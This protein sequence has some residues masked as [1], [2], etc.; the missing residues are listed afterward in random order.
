MNRKTLVVLLAFAGAGLLAFA[1]LKRDGSLETTAVVFGLFV[2]L[3]FVELFGLAFRSTRLVAIVILSVS[4][5]AAADLTY[6]YSTRSREA[7]QNYEDLLPTLRSAQEH[8]DLR[9]LTPEEKAAANQAQ[10]LRS[11][12]SVSLRD[13]QLGSFGALA[14]TVCAFVWLI[15][16]FIIPPG[17]NAYPMLRW[18]TTGSILGSLACGIILMLINATKSRYESEVGWFIGAVGGAVG[19]AL[20]GAVGAAV[21]MLRKRR[22][23]AT[24][25]GSDARA[26]I[27][28]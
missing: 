9:P 3:A 18:G 8:R 1:L 25:S 20:L 23:D 12:I 22:K 24:M 10:Y 14:L 7:F 2:S 21:D 19:G 27:W 13:W 11:R 17:G 16:L 5:L 15:I 26:G 28:P 6:G 4:L